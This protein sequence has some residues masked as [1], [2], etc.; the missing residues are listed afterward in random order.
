MFSP[1]L[2]GCEARLDDDGSLLP[3]VELTEVDHACCCRW[4]GVGVSAR[5]SV[6]LSVFSYRSHPKVLLLGVVPE[7]NLVGLVV[8]VGAGTEAL[9]AL[10]LLMRFLGFAVSFLPETSDLPSSLTA[11]HEMIS[12]LRQKP[13]RL[14]CFCFRE[15]FFDLAG[16]VNS[17]YRKLAREQCNVCTYQRAWIEKSL[18]DH[19]LSVG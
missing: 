11:G 12:F 13:T 16:E 9:I 19:H 14:G 2:F 7:L 6:V 10:S 1:Q 4:C 3:P 15:L 8:A 17:S 18:Q 5:Y